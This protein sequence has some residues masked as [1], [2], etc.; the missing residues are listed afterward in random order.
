MTN[1]RIQYNIKVLIYWVLSLFKIAHLSK[2]TKLGSD[3]MK[4]EKVNEHQI[5]CT[6]TTSDLAEREL[7]LSELVY[8]SEKSKSLFHDMLRQASYEFGFEADDSPLMI[9]AIPMNANSIVLVITKV[10]DPEELDTRFSKFSPTIH[11]DD[12]DDE[13][14]EDM[15]NKTDNLIEMDSEG[16]EDLLDTLKRR[17]SPIM[18]NE[19]TRREQ[20]P[21]PFDTDDNTKQSRMR[22]N[23][24]KTSNQQVA[25]RVK[26]FTFYH[27]DDLIPACRILN[28]FYSGQ[29]VLYKNHQDSTYVITLYKDK[30]SHIDFNKVCNIMSEYSLKERNFI[31]SN[32]YA[33]EHFEPLIKENAIKSLAQL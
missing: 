5:R 14:D 33:S 1:G 23:P 2:Q 16:I 11:E 21:L 26:V 24:N 29:N 28:T 15:V 30:H 32:S 12:T 3:T 10:E 19:T 8:G 17:D 31:V 6:L 25:N 22:T 20:S 4:I 9:E 27:L 18:Q 13:D 7:K